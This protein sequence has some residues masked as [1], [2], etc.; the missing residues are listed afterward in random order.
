MIKI[1]II[2]NVKNKQYTMQLSHHPIT[3]FTASAQAVVAEPTD[4]P[5]LTNL[6]DFAKVR[7]FS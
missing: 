1:I 3:D 2:M 7:N 5:E 6:M 4:F